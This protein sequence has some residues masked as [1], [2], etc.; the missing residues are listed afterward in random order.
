MDWNLEA[1]ENCKIHSR[2]NE[3][4]QSQ[5]W[6]PRKLWLIALQHLSSVIIAF[7]AK[8]RELG[9]ES[10]K[11][12][13]LFSGSFVVIFLLTDLFYSQFRLALKGKE[14]NAYLLRNAGYCIKPY[15]GQSAAREPHAARRILLV[16]LLLNSNNIV[17]LHCTNCYSCVWFSY[18]RYK[19]LL[20]MSIVL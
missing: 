18:N 4:M 9:Q 8:K 17:F 14:F 20:L 3:F 7:L 5:A 15:G 19:L 16:A 13:N 2:L 12:A 1:A 6:S 10:V 11:V